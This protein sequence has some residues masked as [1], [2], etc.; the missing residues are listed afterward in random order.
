MLNLTNNFFFGNLPIFTLARIFSRSKNLKCCFFVLQAN[1]SFNQI[2]TDL[3]LQF[4]RIKKLIGLLTVSGMAKKSNYR[5]FQKN[6]GH[7]K[8][9]SFDFMIELLCF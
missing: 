4:E 8:I 5:L 3:L 6:V 2:A 9:S 7:K 1:V